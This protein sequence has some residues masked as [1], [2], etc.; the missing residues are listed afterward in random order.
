MDTHLMN[1]SVFAELMGIDSKTLHRWYMDFLSDFNPKGQQ[2]VHAND[3]VVGGIE[4]VV[5]VPI[6]CPE[7]IGSDMCIDEKMIGEQFYTILSNRQSGKIAFCAASTRFTHLAQ[8]ML[9]LQAYFEKIQTVT[10]DLSGTYAKLCKELMPYAKQIADKFHIIRNLIEAQQAVRIRHRQKILENKRQAF[11]EF[12]SHE[13][14]RREQNERVGEKFI[15]GKFIYKEQRLS[16]GETHAELLARSHFLLYK[17]S[18]QWT[19]SQLKRAKT[20][21]ECY[22]EIEK[23]YNL[24]C[25]FRKWYARENIGK[26]RLQIERELFQWYEDIDDADIDEMLN[27]K[28]TVESNEDVIIEYFTNGQTNAKAENLN[29][30]VNKFIQANQGV[31]NRDFFFFRIRNFFT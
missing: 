1:I 28:A 16:N 30:Q 3:I 29:G 27:F 13:K 5:E 19:S 11:Q 7:N 9:P 22:P 17:F 31:R 2:Q 18:H 20:L 21:F 12:K 14:Q 24:S 25:Q 15:A 4:N 26:H 23:A 8:A 10:R 6:V